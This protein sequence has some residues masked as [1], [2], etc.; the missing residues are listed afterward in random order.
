MGQIDQVDRRFNLD[1]TTTNCIKL[2]RL[3]LAGINVPLVMNGNVS[4][5][6][7]RFE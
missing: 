6:A 5:L 4:G 2:G 1:P 7:V 3:N